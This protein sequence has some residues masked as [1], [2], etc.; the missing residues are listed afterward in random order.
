MKSRRKSAYHHAQGLTRSATMASIASCRTLASAW[1]RDSVTPEA[2]G[3]ALKARDIEHVNTGRRLLEVMREYIELERPS[4]TQ[5][6]N[7]HL[8]AT[9]HATDR[10]IYG[11]PLCVL[12]FF[13]STY[14]GSILAFAGVLYLCNDECFTLEAG[15]TFGFVPM[16]WISLH[17]F[18]TIGFGNIAPRQT[19]VSAQLVVLFE[20]F[21]ALLIVATI[22]GYVVKLFLR[23]LSAVRFSSKVLVN[24][25]RRR[26]AYSDEDTGPDGTPSGSHLTTPKSG[27]TCSSRLP[28]PT[29]ASQ[30]RLS[31]TAEQA[32]EPNRYRFLTVR[33]V[34][35]GHVQLRDVHVQLQAQ[36]WVAGATAFADRDSHKGRECTLELEQSYFT[37]L[38]QLQVWHRLDERSPLW[39]MRDSL[40]IYIDSLEISVSAY[41]L[42]ALQHVKFYKHYDK[43]D[44]VQNYVFEN[45]LD[46]T[47]KR[48]AG[49]R[50]RLL[51]QADH[52]K[53]DSYLIEPPSVLL[54]PRALPSTA[55]R[56]DLE[57]APAAE[58]PLPPDRAK[59]AVPAKQRRPSLS[60]LFL[61][62][63]NARAEPGHGD[64]GHAGSGFPVDCRRWS[65]TSVPEVEQRKSGLEGAK[66]KRTLERSSTHTNLVNWLMDPQ[67]AWAGVERPLHDN[68]TMD[69]ADNTQRHAPRVP[70]LESGE[71]GDSLDA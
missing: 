20:S 69:G 41:D 36:Y 39:R 35:Q 52:A 57:A 33:M 12:F 68:Q 28:T 63:V 65:S 27:A 1:H 71:R 46:V 37:T 30:R 3:N 50:D 44:L 53:L 60:R 42:A 54:A 6:P 23:P 25:G 16:F 59:G 32:Q 26:V 67:R 61:H 38:E 70:D 48:R 2:N 17:T 55:T 62:N 34:R 18:S 64:S 15:T 43:A 24:S 45:N 7:E 66:H 19:C 29:R 58:P 40:E 13:F 9:V 49:F 4:M 8:C 5:V 22:S 21:W 51:Y 10:A 56:D 31:H 11:P 47:S 14:V